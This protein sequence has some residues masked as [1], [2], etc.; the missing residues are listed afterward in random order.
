M[1]EVIDNWCARNVK[2]L[3]YSGGELVLIWEAGKVEAY[4][5]CTGKWSLVVEDCHDS[6]FENRIFEYTITMSPLPRT[7][8]GKK[9][10]W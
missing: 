9:W 4:N 6:I 5:L 3:P 2:P 8:R 1:G 10:E 7:L